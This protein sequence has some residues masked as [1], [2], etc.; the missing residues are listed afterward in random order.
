MVQHRKQMRGTK[1][2]GK[3]LRK[4][5]DHIAFTNAALSI[6]KVWLINVIQNVRKTSNSRH[7]VQNPEH[8]INLNFSWNAQELPHF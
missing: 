5:L 8:K 1:Y 2:E 4:Q 7:E 6:L 3:I